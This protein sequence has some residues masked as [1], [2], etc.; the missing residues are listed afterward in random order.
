M[1]MVY[2]LN[3]SE[4]QW[5]QNYGSLSAILTRNWTFWT[6]Y[7]ISNMASNKRPSP[8]QKEVM[9]LINAWAFIRIFTGI[10]CYSVIITPNFLLKY[11]YHKILY[12]FSYENL[13]KISLQYSYHFQNRAINLTTDFMKEAPGKAAITDHSFPRHLEERHYLTGWVE[14]LWPSEKIFRSS[15]S[16]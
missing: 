3:I 11:L 7:A 1:I 9:S 16:S 8:S 5:R 14:I 12:D 15:W 2:K 4:D 13:F 10:Y 6:F